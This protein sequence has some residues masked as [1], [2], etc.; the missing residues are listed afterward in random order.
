MTRRCK[1]GTFELVDRSGCANTAL[2]AVASVELAPD[3]L[4][5]V[6]RVL[7]DLDGG[8]MGSADVNN[9]LGMLTDLGGVIGRTGGG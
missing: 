4:A 1:A 5:D 9:V 7:N 6:G 8:N 3:N 2:L